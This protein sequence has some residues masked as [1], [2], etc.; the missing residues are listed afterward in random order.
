MQ[1]RNFPKLW[2]LVMAMV[3]V[4]VFA[5]PAPAR[6]PRPTVERQTR[7]FQN[8]DKNRDGK[9]SLEEYQASHQ[10]CMRDPKCRASLI[11]KFRELDANGD[12]YLTLEEFLAPLKGRQGHR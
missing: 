12:G 2:L 4:L 7:L 11:K 10:A 3:A 9:V 6:A 1:M 5:A 8:L